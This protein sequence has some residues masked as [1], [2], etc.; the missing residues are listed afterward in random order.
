MA[1]FEIITDNKPYYDIKVV[2]CGQDFIQT[3]YSENEGEA[4]TTQLQEYADNYEAGLP[5]PEIEDVPEAGG[6]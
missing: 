3:I 6:E 1:T 5:E 2:A 4:L